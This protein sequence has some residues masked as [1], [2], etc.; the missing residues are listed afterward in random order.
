MP[1]K[2]DDFGD[3]MR[4]WKKNSIPFGKAV[5]QV[6]HFFDNPNDALKGK[7]NAKDMVGL[8]S[9]LLLVLFITALIYVPY[10]AYSRAT[11]HVKSAQLENLNYNFTAYNSTLADQ[12][13][14]DK[15]M[16]WVSNASP[17]LWILGLIL[18][19]LASAAIA[20]LGV[21]TLAAKAV[22]RWLY[23]KLWG[24]QAGFY[25]QFVLDAYIEL[26]LFP[27]S[28]CVLIMLLAG[29]IFSIE[30]LLVLALI[31]A[32]PLTVFNW[33]YYVRG[34]AIIHKISKA[35]A[36][37][38]LFIPVI[39]L[40]LMFAFLIFIIILGAVLILSSGGNATA[41]L[42]SYVIHAFG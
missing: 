42:T 24:G 5:S 8:F 41:P 3:A 20:V 30:W 16:G 22:L 13:A 18:Y 19:L 27:F 9:I 23:L 10:S 4:N 15:V 33:I 12:Q 39:L 31:L 6:R 40:F 7:R 38:A 1:A 25:D 21:V 32:I 34:N 11:D 29:I 28:I 37:W 14:H 17:L 2:K 26:M 35:K 36:F